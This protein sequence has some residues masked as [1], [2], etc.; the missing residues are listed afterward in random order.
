MSDDELPI[1]PDQLIW[2]ER[3]WSSLKVGASWILPMVGVYQKTSSNRL[4]LTELYFSTPVPDA[5]GNTA[6]DSHDWVRLAGS[7]LN[8]EIEEE[9]ELARDWNGQV[10]KEWPKH[11]LGQVAVCD[12]KCG[13]IVRAEPY[14]SGKYFTQLEEATVFT[15][16][17]TDLEN[18]QIAWVQCPTCGKPGFGEEWSGAWV[19][20][21]DSASRLRRSLGIQE[22]E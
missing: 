10:V 11:M 7:L 20:V 2:C 1:S 12:C 18:S 13:T 19:V 15:S 8:W 4:T 22:E 5:F 16:R 9:I 6:F 21:D 17:M 3:L 14:Q